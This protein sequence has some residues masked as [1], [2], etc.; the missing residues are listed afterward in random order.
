LIDA[1]RSQKQK[2]G[3]KV[4]R[5]VGKWILKIYLPTANFGRIGEWVSGYP[6]QWPWMLHPSTAYSIQ[7][8]A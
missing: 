7:Q 3:G 2:M 4:T 8:V 1:A 6:Q 5:H